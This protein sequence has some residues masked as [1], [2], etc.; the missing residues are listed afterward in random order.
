M[1]RDITW[2]DR[3]EALQPGDRCEFHYPA[4][5]EWLPGKVV[6]NAGSGM[7][8]IADESKTRTR[9]GLA[10]VY[11]EGIRLPAQAEAWPNSHGPRPLVGAWGH[12][13]N[14]RAVRAVAGKVGRC[15]T[16]GCDFPLVMV[17][18]ECG[19][20]AH[21]GSNEGDHCTAGKS[22]DGLLTVIHA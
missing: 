11:I 16:P 9:G 3:I 5:N 8:E 18:G 13:A 22:C 21:D 4:R 2:L 20:L 1:K 10:N 12:I 7:W 19:A 17:C 15:Q 14:T 6:R